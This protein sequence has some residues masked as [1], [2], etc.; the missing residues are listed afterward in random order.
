MLPAPMLLQLHAASEAAWFAQHRADD[1]K[2]CKP[3]AAGVI[4][5]AGTSKTKGQ[6]TSALTSS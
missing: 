1:C 3:G 4:Q 5:I 2:D 6:H